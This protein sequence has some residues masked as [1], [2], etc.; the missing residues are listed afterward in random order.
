MDMRAKGME[1]VQIMLDDEAHMMY[2]LMSKEKKG[3]KQ[4]LTAME[5]VTQEHAPKTEAPAEPPSPRA[6]SCVAGVRTRW[7]FPQRGCSGPWYTS[8]PR[9]LPPV[10]PFIVSPP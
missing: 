1:A 5:K 8:R 4:T 10:A 6:R 2:T 9:I 7:L 3:V